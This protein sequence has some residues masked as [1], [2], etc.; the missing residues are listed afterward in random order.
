MKTV[1]V[2][3]VLWMGL[4]STFCENLEQGLTAPAAPDQNT[5]STK[6]TVVVSA[7]KNLESPIQAVKAEFRHHPGHDHN[8]ENNNVDPSTKHTSSHQNTYSFPAHESSDPWQPLQAD[9]FNTNHFSAYSQPTN[10]FSPQFKT[11]N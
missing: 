11:G 10:T 8:H 9:G 3:W 2:F 1:F 6:P 5:A 4:G 7:T